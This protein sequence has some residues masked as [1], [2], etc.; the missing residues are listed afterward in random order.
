[1]F[2]CILYFLIILFT[3]LF[4]VLVTGLP[5]SAS[6]QDLKVSGVLVVNHKDKGK[7]L[8]SFSNIYLLAA[9]Y[10]YSVFLIYRITCVEL[11]MFV[12]HKFS[13]RVVVR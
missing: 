2:Y 11:G 5:H 8:S 12:S 9:E 10:L 7:K 6:W 13:V 3:C 1:M 4:S